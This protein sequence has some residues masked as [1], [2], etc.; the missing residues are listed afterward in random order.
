MAPASLKLLIL[1]PLCTSAGISRH[2]KHGWIHLDYGVGSSLPTLPY[3]QAQQW[4]LL[5]TF[6]FQGKGKETEAQKS[7]ERKRSSK[8]TQAAQALC[9]P[10]SPLLPLP[11]PRTVA[12]WEGG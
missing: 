1:L 5:C 2:P 8:V 10:R 12:S 6:F 11:G 9:L 3:S 7:L 4:V